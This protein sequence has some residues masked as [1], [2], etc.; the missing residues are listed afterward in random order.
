M[1]PSRPAS[2]PS[3][4]QLRVGELVRHAIADILQRGDVTDDAL[5]GHPVTVP[6]VRMSP[7]LKLATVYVMPLGGR[8]EAPVIAALERNKRFIKGALARRI[9]EFKFM[10]D[11]RFRRDDRFDEADRIDRLLHDPKVARDL[12]SARAT[13]DEPGEPEA[14][15]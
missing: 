5:A 13:D 4:R 12:E 11:L 14:E 7:D 10:P 9:R 8:D 3:Q 1:R 6:E 2:G 15:A